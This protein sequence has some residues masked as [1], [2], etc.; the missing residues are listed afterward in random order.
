M[1]THGY[2]KII[3]T[4]D[5][6]KELSSASDDIVSSQHALTEVGT[7]SLSILTVSL[8]V[9]IMNFGKDYD[10]TIYWLGSIC[11]NRVS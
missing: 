7:P 5:Q 4:H 9:L 8:L 2:D 11:G 10:G 6:V 3:L 1:T